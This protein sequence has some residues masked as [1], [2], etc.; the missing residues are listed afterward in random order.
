MYWPV[1]LSIACLAAAVY[2]SL[3]NTAY[4]IIGCPYDVYPEAFFIF[5][6]APA[7]LLALV[8]SVLAVRSKFKSRWR[9]YKVAISISLA[10]SAFCVLTVIYLFVTPTTSACD[11]AP[12]A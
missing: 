12:N 3:T 8:L 10:L 2:F 6:V 1:V 11:P 7:A 5:F 4:V 9:L